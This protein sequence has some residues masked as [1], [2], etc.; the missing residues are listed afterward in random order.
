MTAGT[1]LALV[2]LIS[3]L[4][5]ASV[6]GTAPAEPPLR[7]R[8]EAEDRAHAAIED[9]IERLERQLED[10]NRAYRHDLPSRDRTRF[11]WTPPQDDLRG[12]ANA[13]G[14]RMTDLA[15][16]TTAALLGDESNSAPR[17]RDRAA[18][19]GAIGDQV[20][21]HSNDAGTPVEARLRLLHQ[22]V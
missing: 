1:P 15:K 9:R 18:L 8:Y 21:A 19:L 4:A 12:T 2:P 16:N 22:S 17:L 11:W 20:I 13:T 3:S 10:A 7:E 5:A 14:R 6:L